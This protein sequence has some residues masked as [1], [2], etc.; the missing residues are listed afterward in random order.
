MEFVL[1]C[2]QADAH[3]G[4]RDLCFYGIFLTQIKVGESYRPPFRDV[5][6]V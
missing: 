4:R 1:R 6:V 3:S 5:C 2:K